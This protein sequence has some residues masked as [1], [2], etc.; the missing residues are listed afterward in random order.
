MLRGHLEDGPALLLIEDAHWVDAA[1]WALLAEV[2]ERI[3][4][5]L[6]VLVTGP[7]DSNTDPAPSELRQVLADA[8]TQHLVLGPLFRWPRRRRWCAASSGCRVRP[9]R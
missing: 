7:I 1:S 5:L 9:R 4:P 3:G 6:C 8:A 2:R